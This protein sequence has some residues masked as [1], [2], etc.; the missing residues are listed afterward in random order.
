[1][2]GKILFVKD[3]SSPLKTLVYRMLFILVL[4]CLIAMVFWLDREGL[5]DTRDGEVSPVDVIYF[6]AITIT[7]TGYGDIHPNSTFSM[8]FDSFVATPMRAVIWI[9]FIG[10]A[11]QL[12]IQEYMEERR[13]K[14]L[15]RELKDHVII[16]G[17]GNTGRAV[18]KELLA[19]NYQKEQ[20]MVIDNREDAIK[21]A[22]EDEFMGLLGDPSKESVLNKAAITKAKHLIIATSRD[23]TNV[24]ISLTARDM[25]K[26]IKIIARANQE[27][28]TKLLKTSGA[29]IIISP[30]VAGGHLMAAATHHEH[31]ALLLQDMLTAEHGIKSGERPVSEGEI[32]R[33]PK[34]I[35]GV[36]VIGVFRDGRLMDVR[37]LD[38]IKLKSKDMIVFLERNP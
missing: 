12:I 3:K 6:T 31:L 5:E 14:K 18:A 36:V 9:V 34:E 35:K 11:Y 7:T 38:T 19:K 25:N 8:L 16:T 17:Y 23:D 1:M 28:N 24:L 22:A 27:E 15:Q 33:N 10:T 26:S 30:S 37:E 2:R 13:M 29:D 4:L 32:G 21:E 20:I